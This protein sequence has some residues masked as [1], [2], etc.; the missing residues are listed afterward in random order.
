MPIHQMLFIGD[1]DQHFSSVA[2][3]LHMDG[4]DASTTFTDVKGNAF[5]ANGNAQIDTADFKFGGASGLFDGTGD[6]ADTPDSATFSTGTSDFTIEA[7]VKKAADGALQYFCGQGSAAG[8]DRANSIGFSAANLFFYSDE[9]LFIGT[10]GATTFTVADGWMH[11]ALVRDGTNIRVYKN[12][13]EAGVQ[14]VGASA[15]QNSA[16]KFAVGRLGEFASNTANG[17][18]DDFRFTNGVCRYPS[19][20][21]FTPPTRAFPDV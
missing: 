5:T 8:V 11:V 3:L 1:W 14:A 12:G 19:G 9:V 13:V 2:L 7:W 4:A 18:I 15:A 10:I 20:T 6:Y 21:T 17:W 16:S